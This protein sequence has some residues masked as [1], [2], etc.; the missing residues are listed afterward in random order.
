MEIV[1]CNK[2]TLLL[3][4]VT[5]AK[6][7]KRAISISTEAGQAV[8]MSQEYYDGLVKSLHLTSIPGMKEKLN[9]GMNMPLSECISKMMLTE[10]LAHRDR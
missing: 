1:T 8:V 4:V 2:D 7:K 10:K 6:K 3:E 9:K 5:Q